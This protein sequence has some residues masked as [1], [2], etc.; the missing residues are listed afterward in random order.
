MFEYFIETYLWLCKNKV[1]IS[2][3]DRVESK[4]GIVRRCWFWKPRECNGDDHCKT[5]LNRQ[6]TFKNISNCRYLSL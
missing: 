2:A 3:I 5:N 4:R 1:N 6:R